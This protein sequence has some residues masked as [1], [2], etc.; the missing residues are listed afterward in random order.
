MQRK[1]CGATT[2]Y[3]KISIKKILIDHEPIYNVY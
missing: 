1:S 2:E 3:N